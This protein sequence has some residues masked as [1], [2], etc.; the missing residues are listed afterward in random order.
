MVKWQI[1]QGTKEEWNESLASNDFFS[2]YQSYE[3][4][5]VKKNDG[6]QVVRVFQKKD[7]ILSQAQLFYKPLPLKFGFF[8]CPGG[9]TG[10]NI[11]IDFSDILPEL[12][13]NFYYFRCSFHNP[14]LTP[15]EIKKSGYKECS[16]KINS[17]LSMVLN[18]SLSED[19]LLANMS[20][21][22]RHNLKRGLKKNPLIE[23]WKNPD[24]VELY[25]AYEKFEAMKG[26]SKQH[27][28]NAIKGALEHFGEKIVIL[29]SLDEK[30]QLLALRGFVF[31]GNRALD[32]FAIST[33]I[34][35][36]SYSSQAIIWKLLLLAKELGIRNYDLSGVDPV[37][38][39]GVYNFKKGVGGE[40]ISYPGEFENSSF[41]SF[42]LLFNSLIR[43]KLRNL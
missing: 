15:F 37:N 11:K 35:R 6:W 38:N 27:S 29:R 7:K 17:N 1:F 36:T 5:E 26:L 34:G 31:L 2:L 16:F 19:E 33:D 13:L 25:Q 4:G 12:G 21:N 20:S 10:E 23:I 24:P 18:L 32:W 40:L 41:N 9:I 14:N 22:W 8:W 42:N 3:W 39:S 28:L 43:L 30:N